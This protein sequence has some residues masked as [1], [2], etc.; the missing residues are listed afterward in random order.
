MIHQGRLLAFEIGDVQTHPGMK[1]R[2][3]AQRP[4]LK[5]PKIA[6]AHHLEC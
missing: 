1:G 6:V 4:H 3:Q 5:I 2:F